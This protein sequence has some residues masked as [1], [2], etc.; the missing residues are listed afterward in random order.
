MLKSY[1]IIFIPNTILKTFTNLVMTA[2]ILIGR[3]FNKLFE[4][5]IDLDET[6]DLS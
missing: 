4:V 6:D 1:S 5:V 2:K 3:K